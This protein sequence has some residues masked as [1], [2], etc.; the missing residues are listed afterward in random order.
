M[1]EYIKYATCFIHTKPFFILLTIFKSI[2]FFTMWADEIRHG[3]AGTFVIYLSSLLEKTM[4]SKL[5]NNTGLGRRGQTAFDVNTPVALGCL[6]AGIG[7]T[8]V[9]NLLSSLNNPTLNSV[10]FKLRESQGGK[11]ARL[12]SLPK[13]TCKHYLA[14]EKQQALQNG[15]QVDD[16]NLVPISW[17]YDMSKQNPGKGHNSLTGQE[18]VMSLSS[19]KYWP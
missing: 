16:N 1:L 9:N 12:E 15:V 8:N 2:F 3:V 14:I 17:S 18:A 10:T 5:L 13:S 7:Q 19:G 4:K 6:H 11:A